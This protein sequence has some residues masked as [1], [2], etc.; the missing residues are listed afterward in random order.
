MS[1]KSFLRCT[2]L[3][4]MFT[5]VKVAA[6]EAA[7]AL[8]DDVVAAP[9]LL[10]ST[11]DREVPLAGSPDVT[12]RYFCAQPDT[13]SPIAVLM[14]CFTSPA[15]DTSPLQIDGASFFLCI[16]GGA[17]A[18]ALPAVKAWACGVDAEHTDFYSGITAVA[19]AQVLAGRLVPLDAS[20]LEGGADQETSYK[21]WG[22]LFV[23]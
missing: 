16:V 14:K 22:E 5:L 8:P 15:A 10:F 12:L 23:S 9:T 2:M 18:A 1:L 6:S 13:E 3:L 21:V 7:F 11:Y 19:Y 4:A 20:H 17:P